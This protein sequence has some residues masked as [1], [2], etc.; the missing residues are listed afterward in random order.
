MNKSLFNFRHPTYLSGSAQLPLSER[1]TQ[2][3]AVSLPCFS[4]T[5]MALIS[6]HSVLYG[7]KTSL[8]PHKSDSKGSS[9]YVRK[10]YLSYFHFLSYSLSPLPHLTL[11]NKADDGIQAAWKG[12]TWIGT[13]IQYF[14][15]DLPRHSSSQWRLGA[16]EERHVKLCWQ[17]GCRSRP[18]YTCCSMLLFLGTPASCTAQVELCSFFFLCLCWVQTSLNILPF[19]FTFCRVRSTN[20]WDSYVQTLGHV[21]F[22]RWRQII[23][24]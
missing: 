11:S 23:H 7:S 6:P 18:G 3:T 22:C 9:G 12:F 20:Y 16:L 5:Q 10:F 13:V 14:D 4:F 24:G 15:A 17:S 19:L 1:I 21:L 8:H 2:C